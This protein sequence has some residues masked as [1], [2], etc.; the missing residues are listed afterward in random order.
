MTDM[1]VRSRTVLWAT[2]ICALGLLGS[3][4]GSGGSG[5]D[6][7][8]RPVPGVEAVRA[9]HGTLPL[10]QRLSGVVKATNQVAIY[11]EISAVIT[12]VLVRNG[13]TVEAG[14]PLV[15]LRDKEF[16]D[17]LKQA[18]ASYHIAAAQARQADARLK[19]ARSELERVSDLAERGLVSAAQLEAVETRA[20]VAEADVDKEL[21]SLYVK[22]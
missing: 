13:E 10:T 11:P 21:A 19:E 20:E 1:N 14:Q 18:T 8:E 7:T 9:R 22:T 15:R 5:E 3:A 17:R 4:C 16:R 2:V 6:R 12:E